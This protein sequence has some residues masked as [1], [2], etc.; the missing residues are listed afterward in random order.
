MGPGAKASGSSG[1]RA[2]TRA[3]T[4]RDALATW[5]RRLEAAGCPEPPAEARIIAAHVTGLTLGKVPAHLSDQ[6]DEAALAAADSILARR[7][8]RE[9]LAYILGETE[10][11]GLRLRCDPRAL[12]PRPE[13]ELLVEAA[14]QWLADNP[15][16]LVA[17]VGTGCG[18]VALAIAVNCPSCNVVALE[19]SPGALALAQE[20]AF[21]LGLADRVSFLCG[22]MLAPLHEWGLAKEVAAVVANLP[23][24]SE[25]EYA[26][27]P[28]ELHLEPRDALVAGPT[29]I[30]AISRLAAGLPSLP[31]LEFVALEIGATQGPRACE[32]LATTLPGWSIELRR[33]YAGHDRLAISVRPDRGGVAGE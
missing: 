33:D 9:P 20:N 21:A 7:C 4:L 24:L 28:P 19:N 8:R 18:C 17:D 30:E 2:V 14:L 16:A 12:I 15:G 23:Y 1:Q 13:T 31:A 5:R 10:F 3:L 29:G 22:D 25:E 32:L 6:L 11:F 27:A 26:S